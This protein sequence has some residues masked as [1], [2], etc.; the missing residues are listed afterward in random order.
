M[1]GS[2]IESNGPTDRASAASDDR[3]L[4]L[5]K[6]HIVEYDSPRNLLS[7]T[8]DDQEAHFKALC[9][10]AGPVEYKR[11]RQAVGLGDDDV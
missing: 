8:D 1:H 10:E 4:V 5:S 7:K 11:L 2:L 3:V 9:R 6:G